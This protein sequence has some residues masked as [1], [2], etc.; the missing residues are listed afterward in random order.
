MRILNLIFGKNITNII[1]SYLLPCKIQ[2]KNKFNNNIKLLNNI[3]NLLYIE[4]IDDNFNPSFLKKPYIKV[5][6]VNIWFDDNLFDKYLSF[7]N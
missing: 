3:R 4:T 1:Q 7:Q 5:N 2:N 6:G